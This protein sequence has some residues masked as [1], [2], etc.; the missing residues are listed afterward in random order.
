MNQLFTR[1][2]V[3]AALLLGLSA[4]GQPQAPHLQFVAAPDSGEYIFRRSQPTDAYS[5]TLRTT[6]HLDQVVA[7]Q[8]TDL[9]RV[10]AVCA[11]VH[12]R[13]QHDGNNQPQHRDPISILEEA[14]QGQR[15]RCVEYGVVLSGA[16][17]ALGIPARVLALKTADVETRASGA[18]H[19]VTEAWLADQHKWVLADGQWDVVPLLNGQPL[20][21]VELQRALAA[22]TPGLRV[23]SASGATT[24]RYSRWIQ[25]YLYYFDIG[26]DI[27]LDAK[28]VPGRLMLVPVGAK[29]PLVFQARNPIADMRYTHS[30]SSFYAAPR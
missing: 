2:K 11:W 18:G 20:N 27:R 17:T 4:C 26:F 7:G 15:F 25:P 3:A 30:L 6:Y 24:R 14:A 9:A 16:L 23:A 21:A 28:R 10:R 8:P 12:G 1:L 13:W 22:H 29:N 5:T 19:V